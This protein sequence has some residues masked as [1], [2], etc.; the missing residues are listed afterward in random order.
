MISQNQVPTDIDAED[1][2]FA[3]QVELEQLYN[4]NQTHS[5]IRKEFVECKEI[6]FTRTME[7]NEI[8]VA[9]GYDLLTEMAL[10]KRA[11]VKT[12]VGIMRRH[13]KDL[14]TT[15]DMLIK[16]AEADLV[17]Y[18]H[19]LGQFIVIFNI[20]EDVQLE[21]DRYQFPLPMVIPPRILRSNNDTGYILGQ[22]SVILNHNHHTNDVCLDH[23]NRMNQVRFSLDARTATMVKNQWRNLDRPK[24][25]ETKSDFEK[26]RKAFEKYDRVAHDVIEKLTQHGNVHYMTHRYDKRGRT[27]CMGYHVN[28]QGTPWNK[29]V[30]QL[31]DKEIVI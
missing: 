7:L 22:G 27:Y 20:S 15:A 19:G 16:C 13:L 31:A 23:L 3:L 17:H 10:R 28:Y 18:E 30:I 21:L 11:D 14:Q 5:R 12:L 9:F 25:G 8:P 29:A 4:K 6:N 1:K 2:L 24:E 26:R